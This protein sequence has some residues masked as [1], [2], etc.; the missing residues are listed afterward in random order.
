MKIIYLVPRVLILLC[1]AW[2][3]NPAH[4]ESEIDDRQ[5][6]QLR[7]VLDYGP[8]VMEILEE[9]PAQFD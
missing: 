1:R 2:N 4:L 9:S 8:A 6:N 5:G 3:D 7:F